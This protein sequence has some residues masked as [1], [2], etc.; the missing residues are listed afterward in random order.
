MS[1]P[2]EGGPPP[3]GAEPPPARA[4]VI[5]A[6]EACEYHRPQVL[7]SERC[8][9]FY[10]L[11]TFAPAEIREWLNGPP[12][13]GQ[14]ALC[15]RCEFDTVLGS[16]SGYPITREFLNA[17]RAY[18]FGRALGEDEEAAA[19]ARDASSAAYTHGTDTAAA[20]LR[21]YH[22][23]TRE[24]ALRIVAEGFG[25]ANDGEARVYLFT[26]RVPPL[27]SGA[28]TEVAVLEVELQGSPGDPGARV[29]VQGAPGAWSWYSITSA[30]LHR[31][32]VR[33]LDTLANGRRCRAQGR[34][35]A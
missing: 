17:M 29:N 5:A 12:D 3:A 35:R 16:A 2:R 7:A 1:S 15:P 30:V 11:A 9:C 27:R 20:P 23:T 19:Q 33:L 10:C 28:S 34:W 14:T 24:A 32:R 13:C 26:D 22:V 25:G 18:W 21:L 6:H 31:A 4:A 8:G